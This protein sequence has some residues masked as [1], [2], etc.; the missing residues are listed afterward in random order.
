[1]R[2]RF[3]PKI[4]ILII[5]IC[6]FRILHLANA[7]DLTTSTS[8]SNTAP[9]F[10]VTPSDG[11]SYNG[12]GTGNTVGNPT[13]QGSNITFTAT[14]KDINGDQ[15]YLVI[16]KT[17]VIVEG[18][19]GP[20]TCSGGQWAIS[21]LTNSEDTATAVHTAVSGDPESN[22][23]YAFVCDKL[24]IASGPACSPNVG[25]YGSNQGRAM[26][27]IT[28]NDVPDDEDDVTIDGVQYRFDTGGNGCIGAGICV[29]I[30]DNSSGA[31]TAN[32]LF[33][34][35][36][37]ASSFM[38]N[39]SNI[40]YIYA[41]NS[42]AS[43][44]S[45]AMSI[46]TCANCTLSGATFSGG[47][48]ANASPFYVNHTGTFGQL[49][50]LDQLGGN[51]DPGDTIQF[52]VSDVNLEDTD[53]NGGQDTVEV[54]VCSSESDMG[55]VTTAF[56]YGTL[57]CTN[58]T[59]LC[60][61][62]GVNPVTEN[63]ECNDTQDIVSIPTAHG[64]YDVKIYVFDN[65]GFAATGTTTQSFNVTDTVPVL[66]SYIA[67]DEP[68]PTAGGSDTVDFTVVFTDNNGDNDVT[69]VE[70]VFFDDSAVTSACPPNE[71]NCIRD[72]NCTLA[73]QSTIGTGKTVTGTDALL[74]ADCQ[75]TVWFNANAS[76][77]DVQAQADD[78]NGTTDFTDAGVALT[79]LAISAIDVTE[80]I[81]EYG[82]LLINDA[83]EGRA[84][85]IG[86]M[87][88]QVIDILIEG[89]NMCTDY[90]TCAGAIIPVGQEKWHNT[91]M[92]FNWDD[93]AADPGPW[94]L[95]NSA[96]TGTEVDG[97]INRD[98]AVRDEY[99][100][101]NTNESIFLSIKI[102]T[103]QEVGIYT[104]ANTFSATA[105]TSCTGTLN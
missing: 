4:V 59:L 45:I 9:V 105:S 41:D 7:A 44:N 96:S 15:Y 20:P 74:S 31:D 13:N 43:G 64:G 14:A 99:L 16:C 23:W 29:N 52:N 3:V 86:N 5:F 58:G 1:M 104:G 69:L 101:N 92:I 37:G 95:V 17:D 97:C 38:I 19:D 65:H 26:G 87:G 62:T 88:N 56:D 98:I 94:I 57:T 48:D 51:V 71:N 35:E 75:V 103:T 79:N 33:A 77:F 46:G 102:P 68:A 6:F 18:D 12:S 55:G 90:P 85:S 63:A 82:S 39:Q 70:G 83:S 50:A 36:G 22:D 93:A 10:I 61:D 30:S 100:V 72:T 42:G 78:D 21:E 24:P 34:D 91:S 84:I 49:G 76:D 28:F 66:S 11:G 25:I 80:P 81:T 47:S 2:H 60:S 89:D 27:T 54:Y 73:D 40:V 32:A 8:I 67:I 53:T